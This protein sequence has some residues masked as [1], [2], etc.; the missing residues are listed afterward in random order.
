MTVSGYRLAFDH[1]SAYYDMQ[2][3][4][5]SLDK[6]YNLIVTFPVFRGPPPAPTLQ[7]I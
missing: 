4:T 3:A 2:L 1:E 6:Y 7:F 5:F